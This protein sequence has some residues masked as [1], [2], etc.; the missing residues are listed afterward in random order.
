MQV[1]HILLGCAL[2]I[3]IAMIAYGLEQKFYKKFIQCKAHSARMQIVKKL[4]NMALEQ[5]SNFHLE[6]LHGEFKGANIVGTCLSLEKQTVVIQVLDAFASHQWANSTMSFYFSIVDDQK[7]SFYHFTGFCFAAKRQGKVTEL[8]IAL[9][10]IID[11]GQRRSCLRFIPPKNSVRGLGL[12]IIPPNSPL[13]THKLK[14]KKPLLTYDPHS[15]N[16][17]FLDNVSAGGLRLCVQEALMPEDTQILEKGTHLLMV[18]ALKEPAKK[19]TNEPNANTDNNLKNAPDKEKNSLALWLSCR[20]TSLNHAEKERVWHMGVQFET[21]ATI[22][23]AHQDITWFPIDK[24]GYIPP[25][26]VW[27]MR[28]HME[29]EMRK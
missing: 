17:I 11:P 10:P 2:G 9:P 20:V 1:T 4:L 5:R 18:L 21:W 12:W 22:T 3:V 25:L 27:V 26:S 29:Q 23:Q 19:H 13:P 15:T 14:L 28:C 8:S 6:I 24:N 16:S 7:T